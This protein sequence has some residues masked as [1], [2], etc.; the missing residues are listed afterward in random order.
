MSCYFDCFI[1]EAALIEVVSW[2]EGEIILTLQK[3]PSLAGPLCL[4]LR[5]K[6]LHLTIGFQ[7]LGFPGLMPG[8]RVTWLYLLY[9]GYWWQY[10][11]GQGWCHSR[12]YCP[13]ADRQQGGKGGRGGVNSFQDTHPPPYFFQLKSRAFSVTVVN[14]LGK[15]ENKLLSENTLSCESFFL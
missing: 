14:D 7:T 4:H 6:R 5:M 9:R 15:K 13:Q 1:S 2:E 8:L 10:P 3:S 12:L 11:H